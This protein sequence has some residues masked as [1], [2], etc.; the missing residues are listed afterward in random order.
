LKSS[1]ADPEP[2]LAIAEAL[3]FKTQLVERGILEVA[4][5]WVLE[6]EE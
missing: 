6:I 1:I 4:L 2:E 5:L 3:L